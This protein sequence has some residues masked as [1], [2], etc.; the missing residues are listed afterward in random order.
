MAVPQR[1]EAAPPVAYTDL[2][3]TIVAE[4]ETDR[5]LVDQAPCLTPAPR[6]PN[7]D[8]ASKHPMCLR[9]LYLKG[10]CR[11]PGEKAP[12]K[13][14]KVKDYE[15]DLASRAALADFHNA[16]VAIGAQPGHWMG[17]G[18][19]AFYEPGPYLRSAQ[20]LAN[21]DAISS[22]RGSL[23]LSQTNQLVAP[24]NKIVTSPDASLPSNLGRRSEGR[25]QLACQAY[26]RIRGV[27]DWRPQNAV[28]SKKAK[29]G[30]FVAQKEETYRMGRSLT[31]RISEVKTDQQT[32]SFLEKSKRQ[33]TINPY[34]T[35]ESP[36]LPLDNT[37]PSEC[38]YVPTDA[39]EEL[40]DYLA[41]I[42]PLIYSDDIQEVMRDWRDLDA[43][44][45]EKIE[46]NGGSVARNFRIKRR[47]RLYN[48]TRGP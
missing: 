4:G 19:Q 23:F 13:A 40:K 28:P 22:S 20:I 2:P 33:V 3:L 44:E 36:N 16:V 34:H 39:F 12:H 1:G 32:V 15:W 37:A 46:R 38:I 45:K 25:G 17:H 35:M 8:Q 48:L 29:I 43:Q 41:R 5:A 7:P 10:R 24:G 6:N 18:Q 9:C 11:A 42:C 26:R 21:G 31:A 14:T 30:C 27:K 47:R